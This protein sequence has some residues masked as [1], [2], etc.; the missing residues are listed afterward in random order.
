MSEVLAAFP[1]A[2]QALM[3]RYH[4]GGCTSCGFVLDER[5]GDVLSRHGV[6]DVNEVIEHIQ[7]YQEQEARIQISPRQLAD[8]LAGNEATNLIDVRGL[9]EFDIVHLEGARL[10][11][12]EL[13]EEM[14]STWSKDT[15]IVTYCH[16]GIR[17]LEAASFLI[18]HGL[19]DVRSLTG[20]IDAWAL[21]IDPKLPRY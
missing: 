3:R 1:G 20:G 15:P 16:H 13:I 4:I 2:Q 7:T 12:A 21:E 8:R 10:A 14:K 18:G 19:T 11:T 5:L 17:S 6:A 9:E